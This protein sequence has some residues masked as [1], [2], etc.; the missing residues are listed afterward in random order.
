MVI[1]W[2]QNSTQKHNRLIFGFLLVV[3][4]VSFVFYTGSG[5]Q[6]GALGSS[7]ARYLDI[8]LA[9]RRATERFDDALT[10]SG[11]PPSSESRT[12]QL[13]L[14]IAR[15]HLADQLEI[16]TPSETN[17]QERVR[18]F[19]ARNGAAGPTPQE[20]E[21][22]VSRLQAELGCGRDEALA[23]LQ[24]V[25]E[26]NLR[27]EKAARLLGGP[28]HA[29]PQE[30]RKALE[31]MDTRWT[32]EVAR[33][34]LA[35]FQPV[36]ADD[37]VKA[38]ATFNAQAERYRLPGR[39]TVRVLT[40]PTPAPQNRSVSDEEILAHAYNFAEELGIKADNVSEQAMRRKSEITQRILARSSIQEEA[41]RLSDDLLDRFPEVDRR[42]S[43]EALDRWL[44]DTKATAQS[45]PDFAVGDEPSL[46]NVPA[47][48][49]RAASALAEATGW[50]TEF[51]PSAAGPL[52]VI[53]DQRTPSR[54]PA[55]EE[56]KVKALADWRESE[57]AAAFL[58]KSQEIAASLAK[59]VAGGE[60]YAT[61]AKALGLAVEGTL[62]FVAAEPPASLAGPGV[63]VETALAESGKGKVTEPIPV[64]GGDFVFLYASG[65]EV[66][67]IDAK[68]TR[69]QTILTAVT[70]QQARTTLNGNPG[71]RLPNGE[72]IGAAGMGL[73]DELT[74]APGAAA[75]LER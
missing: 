42:P 51:Y 66:P 20:W 64:T 67:A 11:I 53:L 48:A 37:L 18:S 27:W 50:H 68:D 65:Q 45:L 71:I 25:V 12:Y 43:N 39:V 61:A 31:A 33:L 23:R 70:Q 3:V 74:T 22:F 4:G 24:R 35:K 47:A 19:F 15:K 44:K 7:S 21:T 40:F 69:F 46:K 5:S 28:G 52:V 56:V 17:V 73:L 72:I 16:P 26:D 10:L 54:I 59:S 1:T 29:S 8:D 30:V 14:S 9:D 75:P 38:Q 34:S 55:F 63:R 36:I 13:C 2:L 60:S 57:R 62:N 41:A 58:R 49:L 32:V 6:A